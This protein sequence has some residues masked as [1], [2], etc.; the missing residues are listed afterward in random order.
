MARFVIYKDIKSEYRWR[1]KANNGEIIAV[2]SEGYTQKQNVIN[3]IN[4]V[5]T[6]AYGAE[7]VDTTTNTPSNLFFR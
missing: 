6:L 5:R 1:F 2:S 3:S 4:L 7:V